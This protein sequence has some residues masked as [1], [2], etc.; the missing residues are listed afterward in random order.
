MPQNSSSLSECTRMERMNEILF[1]FL[2]EITNKE[3]QAY[4]PM[5]KK[6]I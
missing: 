4:P 1:Y 3:Q 6:N 2:K 5:F